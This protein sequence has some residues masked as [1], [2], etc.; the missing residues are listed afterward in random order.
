MRFQYLGMKSLFCL[1]FTLSLVLSGKPVAA[2]TTYLLPP[3]MYMVTVDPVT[4]FDI[5]SWLPSTSPEIDYYVIGMAV[6]TLPGQ[7]ISW[8]PVGRTLSAAETSFVNQDLSSSSQ[9]IGYAVWGVD[10]QGGSAIFAGPFSKT[11][12]TMFL[13]ATL[14]SCEAKIDLAWNEY[15]SWSGSIDHY[16]IIR[17]LGPG[18]TSLLGTVPAGTVNFSATNLTIGEW[19][20]I[21]VEAVHTDGVRISQSNMVQLFSKMSQLPDFINADFAT[22]SSDHHVDLSFT[23]DP[24]SGLTQ[25]NLQRSE[26]PSGPY[27]VIANLNTTSKHISYTDPV[28]FISGIRY[29]RLEVVNNCGTTSIQSNL[30][31]NIILN[32]SFNANYVNLSW[33]D[34]LDW[35]GGVESYRVIRTQGRENTTVDTINNYLLTEFSESLAA[36]IDYANPQSS[37]LCYEVI[38]TENT[39]AHGI[40]G[41]SLSNQVCFSIN[42]HVIMP[43]AFIPNDIEPENQVFE[44]VFSI[45][46]E[47]YDMVVYNRLGTVVWEGSGPWDGKSG[48]KYVP[49]GVY[50]YLIR[51]YNYS[52]DIRDLNGKV[53]VVYR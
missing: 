38:A 6:Q 49:E 5:I 21:Y 17:W 20:N 42:P 19:Y 23:V 36:M 44:P 30:S 16:N 27:T 47:H 4:G 7:P 2:Q 43:N 41:S 34:Y 52:S 26:D 18:S 37:Y 10:D 14:D 15:I 46:P 35:A 12:S 22:I 13:T 11:D 9:S 39:N 8:L 1:I 29:Y 25:Y 3:T 24:L 40:K 33:N 48:N 51:I 31:N 50:V 53:T 28:P 45:Q 32:G